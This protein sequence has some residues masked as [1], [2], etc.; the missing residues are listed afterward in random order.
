MEMD[1]SF[2]H[3]SFNKHSSNDSPTLSVTFNESPST[4]HSQD[5]SG[6]DK[7]IDNV[8]EDVPVEDQIQIDKVAEDI[9]EFTNV[10]STTDDKSNPPQVPDSV[11]TFSKIIESRI[12]KYHSSANKFGKMNEED[13]IFIDAVKRISKL[14]DAFGEFPST[15]ST[16][17]SLNRTSSVLQRAM[18]FL[19]EEFRALLEEPSS[20]SLVISPPTSARKHGSGTKILLKNVS[21]F[22]SHSNHSPH[23]K[24]EESTEADQEKFDFPGYSPETVMRMKE[25]ATTMISAGYESECC[26]VYSIV[27]RSAFS[28]EMK[29]KLDFEKINMEDV[30]RMPWETLEKEISRWVKVVKA[31]AQN[32]FPGER[33]LCTEVFSDHPLISRSLYSNLARAIVINLLDFAEAVSM[34]KRSAEK[35]FK[36]LDV[37]ETLRDLALPDESDSCDNN[38]HELNAEITNVSQRIG[39]AAVNIF[40]DLETSIDNDVSRTPVPGGAVHPLTRYVMNYLKLASEYKETLEIIFTEHEKLQESSPNEENVDSAGEEPQRHS[41]ESNN[42]LH[43]SYGTVASTTPFSFQLVKVMQL[44]DKNLE[45]KSKLYRDVSLSYVFLMNNGRYILQR[46]KGST[47]IHQVM[48]DYW[49]R[50]R[51]TTVRQF[52]KNYQR[53]TWGKVLQILSHEGLM[54]GNKPNKLLL[55]ERFKQFSMV[56]DDIHKTQS[57][58]VVS[59][60]QLQSEL[61]VSITAVVI[62]AYRSFIGR[63]RQYL[64]SSRNLS[65]Y[66]KYQPDDIEILI[67]DLFGGIPTSMA[68]RR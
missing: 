66:I 47:E 25:I 30:H 49:C 18:T 35:L 31:C 53:E 45:E 21:S 63:F 51:S 27:R 23:P 56:F 33:K 32:L 4:L 11:E 20:S 58:W 67:E 19:E 40:T 43:H 48:G 24:N 13:A 7:D 16:S 3:G 28:D 46:V 59:D 1:L 12:S 54:V 38:Q 15:A 52:H 6:L 36:F 17:S 39:E 42:S 57:T 10:L 50:K 26:Q 44:L 61:R 34:T 29:K 14:A 8:E 55:K 68:R 64:E 37:H 2:K 41:V 65:K 9:D 62:P 5:E 60:E 22:S